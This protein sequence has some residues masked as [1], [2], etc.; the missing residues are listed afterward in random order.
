MGFVVGLAYNLKKDC[1]GSDMEVEDADAEF[2]E[3]STVDRIAKALRAGGHR[4][5]KIPYRRGLL[6]RLQK[7]NVDIVFNIAEGWEGRCREAIVPAILESLGIP[8]TGSDPLTL[9]VC[10]DKAVTKAIVSASGIPTPWCLKVDSVNELNNYETDSLNYPLF[11]KPA[12]EGSSKGVRNSSKVTDYQGLIATVNWI[13]TVYK[14]PALIE[15][16]LPGRE[17]TVGIVGNQEMTVFPIME[18]RPVVETGPESF[19]YCYNTKH[20]NLEQF[21]CPAPVT[22]ELAV[23]IRDVA[24]RSYRALECRDLARVDVRLD[25]SG[26]P[27]FLEINPLPGLSTV[28]LFPITAMASG[29]SFEELVWQ[30]LDVAATRANVAARKAAQVQ[31]HEIIAEQRRKTVPLHG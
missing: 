27:N 29:L 9:A 8:Y 15:E 25:S 30:I 24:I 6:S 11:V 18:V 4:V 12:Y 3:Q 2:E 10:L 23:A 5:V 19:V 14:Q 31:T 1:P 20:N 13:T 22:D 7:L 16:F 28:S 17:F 26:V 21:L